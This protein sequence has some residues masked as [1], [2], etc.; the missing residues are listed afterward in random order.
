MA[1]GNPK[2]ISSKQIV[3][4]LVYGTVTGI[5]SAAAGTLLPVAPAIASPIVP[6]AD[7]TNTLVNTTGDRTQIS[8][9]S[10]VNDNLFHH[11]DTFS[12]DA[13]HTADFVVPETI[14]SVFGQIS[15]G[16]P[17]EIHGTLAVSGS[18]ADLFLLNPAGVL[19]GPD[20][21]LNLGGSLTATT[22]DAV[23]FGEAW[24][25]VV[26]T[27]E[28]ESFEQSPSSYLFSA[29]QPAAVVNQ[30]ALTVAEKQS[31]QL[32]GGNVINTGQLSAPDGNITLTA[33]PSER[34]IRLNAEG[35]LLTIEISPEALSTREL[36]ALPS[37]ALPALLTGKSNHEVTQLQHSSHGTVVLSAGELDVS[38]NRPGQQGGEINL[39]GTAVDIASSHLEASGDAGGGI[40]RI[41]GDYQGR[42]NLPTAETV[43]FDRESTAQANALTSG[44][45]G[46][47]ILWSEQSTQFSGDI[48]AQGFAA[49][50]LVETSSR[51]ELSVT[52]SARVNATS[53][54]GAAGT[55]L[56]DP[57]SLTVVN[58]GGTANIVGG[59]NA[60]AAATQINAGTLV[61]AL[62]G[63]NV[64]LQADNDITV[65]T[66]INAQGNALAGNLR[67]EA[68]QLNLNETISLRPGSTLSGTP[69]VVNLG[70]T[71]LLQ[72]AVDAVATGGVI[73]AAA[74]TYTGSDIN[75]TLTIRGQGSA[76]TRFDGANVQR[77]FNISGG[78]VTIE[79]AAIEN[80]LADR[81]AGILVTGTGG[82]TLRNSL[83]ENNSTRTTTSQ[84]H[85]GGI[86]LNGAGTSLIDDSI[87]QNNYA[88]WFG[89]A[90]RTA[91]GHDITI[92]GS[93]F[94]NNSAGQNGGA[95]DRSIDSGD[96]FLRGST[97]FDNTA[98]LSGGAISTGRGIL[99]SLFSIEN[100]TFTDNT[101]LNNHGGALSNLRAPVSISDS[102]FLRNRT[103]G[104]NLLGGAIFTN[105]DLTV[106]RTRF[107][108]S[109]TDGNGGAIYFDDGAAGLISNAT[110]DNNRSLSGQGGAL[111]FTGA[112]TSQI[113]ETT[114][115]NNQSALEGGGIYIEDPY[116][117]EITRSVLNGNVAGDDGGAI[118]HNSIGANALRITASTL[119]N[120][121]TNTP[122]AA[123][124]AVSLAAN[125]SSIFQGVTIA[126][127]QANIEGGGIKIN[128]AAVLSLA[129]SIVAGNTAVSNN[130]IDGNITSGGHNLVQSR[131]TSGGYIASD[132]PDGTDPLLLPLADNGGE[133]FTR[134][135]LATS[136]ALNQINN[137]TTDQR[138]AP[139]SG[140]RDIGAYELLTASNL[141]FATGNG[142]STTV[143]TAFPTIVTV[144]VTDSLGG[145]LSGIPVTFSQG[146][147]AAGVVFDTPASVTTGTDGT[148]TLS[149]SANT[150]AGPV[151]INAATPGTAS[152]FITVTNTPDVPDSLAV[153]GGN[154]QS[155][156]INTAFPV[157]L[158]VQVSD[159]FGNAIAGETVTFSA[160]VIG[161]SG[162]LTNATANTNTFGEGVTAVTANSLAGDYVVSATNAGRTFFFQLTNLPPAPPPGIT[163]PTQTPP[164]AVENPLSPALNPTTVTPTVDSDFG[165]QDLEDETEG[166]RRI[167][168]FDDIAFSRLEASLTEEYARYWQQP[169]DTTT[170]LD[171]LQQVLQQAE[172][173]YQ[174]RSAVIY[175]VF[176]PAYEQNDTAD[177]AYP[178]VLS[179]RL[180][181][182]DGTNQD[183]QLLLIMIPPEGEP[184]Q[185]LL[186]VTRREITRQAQLF[187]IELSSFLTEGYVPL[188]QQLYGWLM[189]PIA[190]DLA[191]SDID[192]VVYV[193]D[194]GLRAL[195]LSAMMDGDQFAIEHYG[196]STLPSA[197]LL[198]TDFDTQPAEQTV[199]LGGADT[200]ET[201][202]SLPAVP[203]ELDL[204]EES[205][206]SS[207]LL[208]N[209]QFKIASLAAVQA[210]QPQEILHLATHAEFN[211]GA[212]NRSYIQFWE[213]QLTLDDIS[214]LTLEDLELLVLSACT[215]ALGSHEAE[216][217]F[218]GL[219][220]FTGAETAIG[221]IWNVSDV[222]TM[223]LMANFY[224]QLR[225]NPL[226]GFALQQ[227]QLSLLQGHTRIENNRL[228]TQLGK[229]SVPQAL[230]DGLVEQGDISF[231]HPFFWSGFTLVGSPWW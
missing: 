57:A 15:G 49:G 126:D 52:E 41:G 198:Q 69:N 47:V 184:T 150:V 231:E 1:V 23:G 212:I 211:P 174:M 220:A 106:S 16:Q 123:G 64:V 140:L 144:G 95:L 112:G 138:G 229:H 178:S 218:A 4:P 160:P 185:Q 191:R 39:F 154:N 226:R 205:A 12:V 145:P 192:S 141:S 105:G 37:V 90:L 50:G 131:G 46:Q 136:P 7:T 31:I 58:G 124:G 230:T 62:N 78:N 227:A 202:D 40:I 179:N 122:A 80:G 84:H 121:R 111:Y 162:S 207:R 188:A 208:F 77:V 172:D 103:Q 72:N 35:A 36:A 120:N 187:G 92:N 151:Q 147:T 8:G 117:L 60:P 127:N 128:G 171:T 94:F 165:R 152:P 79:D 83:V 217:G 61:S 135:F 93:I 159:Q 68:P 13:H 38:G 28:Y 33:A 76:N 17:S 155:T 51:G 42:G 26:S 176:V 225:Q 65:D 71:G 56:L 181:Q 206:V 189:E 194:R 87:F 74:A 14:Q 104:P 139:A 44:D 108:E 214:A 175:G 143:D 27:T 221:S 161:P 29:E 66:A 215:T 24:L 134:A 101:A 99:G 109:R 98:T 193:L 70:P 3:L 182:T 203:V 168:L 10:Q 53:A 100:S 73:N 115:S 20:A 54:S 166:S 180:L 2:N 67:L 34:L 183:D 177:G 32:I 9:G 82:L 86:F 164:A 224:E 30:A 209:E 223:A 200:F 113:V 169:A 196:I 63:A 197:S 222:G 130:D 6:A 186:D 153:I 11:F 149:V 81:G 129:N 18:S 167:A 25:D 43:A 137:T 157:P 158:A 19:F 156:Q 190:S 45:G 173:A 125:T 219:A 96:F 199:L 170:T 119:S 88:D 55:W 163:P 213:E 110:L 148:A 210:S 132:L 201:L 97:L 146:L 85:G 228:I 59:T 216:L 91:N 48:S 116:A 75:R 204:V 21:Q 133:T 102:L 5:V 114:L 118:F 89:G 195:P 22:A 142:Q 107:E